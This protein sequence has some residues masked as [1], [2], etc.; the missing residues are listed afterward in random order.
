MQGGHKVEATIG[1]ARSLR[2]RST[3]PKQI[4]WNWLPNRRLSG[5]KF[6]RQ[7][8]SGPD[9]ADFVCR[10][11]HLIVEVDG[12]GHARSDADA[13]RD[14]FPDSRGYSVLRFWNPEVLFER[15]SVCETIVAAI[16][17]CL[18]PYDRHMKADR[19]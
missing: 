15:E 14:Q 17:G 16:K 9:V 10:E 3:E 18:E 7:V 11:A 12:S 2:H 5:H 6:V 13:A 19:G 1:Q 8:P 4:L